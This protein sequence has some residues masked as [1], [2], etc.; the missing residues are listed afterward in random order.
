M[1]DTVVNSNSNRT[2]GFRLVKYSYTLTDFTPHGQY[3]YEQKNNKV[4]V[5]LTSVDERNA[6]YNDLKEQNVRARESF[7]E[8]FVPA[9]LTLNGEQVTF[10]NIVA[11]LRKVVESN[12]STSNLRRCFKVLNE[13]TNF[14]VI[15]SAFPLASLLNASKV[16]YPY[17]RSNVQQSRH[18]VSRPQ[19]RQT[20]EVQFSSNR[21]TYATVARGSRGRG[22]ANVRFGTRSKIRESGSGVVLPQVEVEVKVESVPEST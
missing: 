11:Y 9:S 17:R 21:K 5:N 6:F 12:D 15:V 14:K 1:T 2:G 18:T 20:N 3:P 19:Q 7:Y 22:S 8:Y 16:F 4:Y 13:K 10:Q